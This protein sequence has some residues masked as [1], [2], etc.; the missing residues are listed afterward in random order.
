LSSDNIVRALDRHK[1]GA[2]WMARCAAHND[3]NQSLSIKAA[4]DAKSWRA[5]MPGCDQL[6]MIATLRAGGGEVE[7]DQ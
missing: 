6:Q 3:R 4:D 2:G 1:V 5:T 7:G